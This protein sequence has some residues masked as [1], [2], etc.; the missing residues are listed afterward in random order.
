MIGLIKDNQI[1]EQLH[2]GLTQL[3]DKLRNISHRLNKVVIDQVPFVELVKGACED[4]QYLTNVPI[5]LVISEMDFGLSDEMATH[6][7]RMIQELLNNAVKYVNQ[8]VINL[9]VSQEY[10]N[11]YIIY[12]DNGPGFDPKL[13]KN[14]GIGLMNIY[15]RRNMCMHN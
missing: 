10:K 14:K 8:G 4:M 5:N 12:N 2:S 6:S 3:A 9:S 1:Q 15:E 7:F 11:L 13:V